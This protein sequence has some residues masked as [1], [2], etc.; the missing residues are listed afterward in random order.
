[1]CIY[2]IIYDAIFDIANY[3]LIDLYITSEQI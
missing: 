2:E 3:V 1:M